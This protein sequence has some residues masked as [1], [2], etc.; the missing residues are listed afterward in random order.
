M[1]TM[2]EQIK[3]A[4]LKKMNEFHCFGYT[5]IVIEDMQDYFFK[6]LWKRQQPETIDEQVAA[7]RSLTANQLF[8]FKLLQIQSLPATQLADIQ[9]DELI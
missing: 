4:L 2:D 3:Q 1:Q 7:I 5:T 8:D 9:L 6:F